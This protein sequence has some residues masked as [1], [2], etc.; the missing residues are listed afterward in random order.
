MLKRWGFRHMRIYPKLVVTFLVVLLPLNLLSL[1]MNQA[2][3]ENVKKE[4]SSATLSKVHFYMGLIEAEILRVMKSE[5]NF[6]L[7]EDLLLLALQG[8][9]ID[10][11][12]K[13]E[14]FLR[15]EQ[16]LDLL[17]GSSS[18]I[19]NT[20]L[21]IP[22]L[23]RT[24]TN[25]EILDELSAEYVPL[26]HISSRNDAPFVIW[27]DNM[28]LNFSYPERPNGIDKKEPQFVISL[29]VS[30]KEFQRVLM[31]L[32]DGL[33][34]E[35]LLIGEGN[36]W[37][38][39]SDPN[40]PITTKIFGEMK[41]K[42]DTSSNPYMQTVRVDGTNYIA[43]VEKSSDIGISL[44][45]MIPEKQFLGPLKKYKQWIWY[46]TVLTALI[47]LLFSYRLYRE[48]HFPLKRLIQ[49]F[50]KVEQGDLEVKVTHSS[51]DEFSYLYMRFNEMVHQVKRLV[52]EVFEQKYRLRL[53]ELK[54]LQ[55][56]IN[57]H[58]L[59]NSYFSLYYMVKNK[60][61]DQS[62]MQFIK[63]LGEYFQYITRDA[64]EEVP[65]SIEIKHAI[66]YVAIQ[67][68]RFK[69]RMQTHISLV[70]EIAERLTVPRLIL[71]PIIENAYKHG[72]EE[73]VDKGILRIHFAQIDGFFEVAIED[74]G[75]QLS[76]EAIVNLEKKL[77]NVGPGEE[78]TGIIN[79]HRRLVIRYGEDSG[80]FISRGKLGGFQVVV[81]IPVMDTK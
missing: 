54:Q 23:K 65:L 33:E 66:N 24:I 43:F 21:H 80:L 25:K 72:L 19:E 56:Q 14:A 30:Q 29:E 34:D 64:V 20:L 76:D 22:L 31:Q 35:A 45:V 1:Y 11:N 48:I 38:L 49:A 37:S 55:S 8:D 68:I 3:S 27:K 63:Y 32:T 2:S 75:T 69:H 70:P 62:V 53:S 73:K 79:V 78:T 60:D 10:A 15:L 28:Y 26:R 40:N 67:N 5:Q 13:R 81:R 47:I 71:Q 17:K 4:I 52:Q 6:I 74:N 16:R 12:A 77:R 51:S 57:P 50:R 18:F 58:F 42:T 7:D 36:E 59:Y 61:D 46:I 44:A 9:L 41:A 39:S